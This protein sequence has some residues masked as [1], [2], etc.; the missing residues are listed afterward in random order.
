MVITYKGYEIHVGN[1]GIFRAR[2]KDEDVEIANGD[3]LADLKKSLNKLSKKKFGQGVLVKPMWRSGRVRHGKISCRVQKERSIYSE[4]NPV[5]LIVFDDKTR[6]QI[7]L[8]HLIKESKENIER[9]EKI[10]ELEKKKCEIE[11]EIDSITDSLE[12]YTEKELEGH[13]KE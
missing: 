11:E 3:N 1:D 5:Y 4:E 7:E 12:S 6:E 2:E 9:Y 8:R 13:G 10:E